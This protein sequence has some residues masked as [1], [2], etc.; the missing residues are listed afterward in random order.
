MSEQLPTVLRRDSQALRAARPLIENCRV[1]RARVIDDLDAVD[2]AIQAL[3][4]EAEQVLEEAQ[5]QAEAIR[6]EA[7]KQGRKEGLEECMEALTKA[8]AEYGRLRSRAEQ[9][10]VTLAFQIARRI[11]GH[12]IEVQPEVVRDIVG[13]ALVTARGRRQIEVRVHPEDCERV[14]KQRHEYAR[15]LDGV[16]VYF[17]S[18]A[19]L[20]RGDCVIETE[21]GR[22]DARLE[23]QLEVLRDALLRGIDPDGQL[24]NEEEK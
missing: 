12:A 2:D 19:G 24:T 20:E 6:E 3:R 9:D 1:L 10:M 5:K 22:I 13:E 4:R 14:E 7:R 8:R 23:T 16:P 18:D 15:E 17:E 11:I 21:S